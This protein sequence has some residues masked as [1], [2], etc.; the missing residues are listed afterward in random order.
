MKERRGDPR[1][2]NKKMV[3][4]GIGKKPLTQPRLMGMA[5]EKYGGANLD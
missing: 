1:E 2:K 3:R 5:G 4:K